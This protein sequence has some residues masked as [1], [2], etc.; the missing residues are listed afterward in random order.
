MRLSAVMHHV[1]HRVG[2]KQL[3]SKMNQASGR[4]WWAQGASNRWNC[5]PQFQ[6]QT[7]AVYS[8]SNSRCKL[9]AEPT[10]KETES[11]VRVPCSF[12]PPLSTA[13]R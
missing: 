13:M 7:D 10:G 8:Q 9:V 4:H 3:V 12:K 11:F 5:G 1:M 2:V 6:S